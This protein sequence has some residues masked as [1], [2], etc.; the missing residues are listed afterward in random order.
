MVVAAAVAVATALRGQALPMMMRMA[1]RA[2]VAGRPRERA[3]P[4]RLGR[5]TA[6]AAGA[7]GWRRGRRGRRGLFGRGALVCADLAPTGRRSK[8]VVGS[9]RPRPA[10]PV[11]LS[12]A[13][14]PCS[15]SNPSSGASWPLW[16]RP[17]RHFGLLLAILGICVACAE[18]TAAC[19]SWRVGVQQ[20]R[21]PSQGAPHQHRGTHAAHQRQRG[22]DGGF[23]EVRDEDSSQMVAALVGDGRGGGAAV[24]LRARA[25]PFC[26]RHSLLRGASRSCRRTSRACSS[27]PPTRKSPWPWCRRASWRRR[28]PQPPQA[29]PPPP[30]PSS[31]TSINGKEAR[32]RARTPPKLFP[33][34]NYLLPHE[35]AANN[36][37]ER[38][39]RPRTRENA[40]P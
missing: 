24:A 22:G 38:R 20:R 26:R 31:P 35:Q 12:A 30:T 1:I 5:A 17:M 2:V 39:T 10:A 15:R 9:Q 13:I 27:R 28:L 34:E 3:K 25:H 18:A 19:N 7:I 11:T 21:C 6:G 23:R 16:A 14:G 33:L 8:I 29:R 37:A 32:R 36:A 40:T 4:P